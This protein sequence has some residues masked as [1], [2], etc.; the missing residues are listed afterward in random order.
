MEGKGIRFFSRPKNW[1]QDVSKEAEL[2][3][4][5]PKFL[6]INFAVPDKHY[7]RCQDR[8]FGKLIQPG[9]MKDS[10]RIFQ[11]HPDVALMAD[12]KRLSKGLKGEC[13]G[14]ID[15]WS[16][17]GPLT[18]VDKLHELE[19]HKRIISDGIE[20]LEDSDDLDLYM[21]LQHILKMSS[22]R[23]KDI[24]AVLL[25]QTHRLSYLDGISSNPNYK[26]AAK[27]AC[28]AQIN[29]FKVF[30]NKALA[31][32]LKICKCLAKLQGTEDHFNPENMTLCNVRN[33]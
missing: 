3:Q 12:C 25:K 19:H 27:S 29:E 32:N 21:K 1:G 22:L 10:L 28:K 17:E 14:D 15:L 5:D 13:L 20:F 23:I 24:R 33:V 30:I 8:R 9:I 6:E 18:L 11:D 16:H 31:L 2:G 26:I 4:Y 7:L